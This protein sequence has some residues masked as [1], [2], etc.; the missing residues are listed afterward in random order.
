M[1]DREPTVRSRELG[2]RLRRVMGRS[3]FHASGI[4]REL[5]WSPSRVSRVLAEQRGGSSHAKLHGALDTG[6]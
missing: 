5:N 4:A 1:R 6:P 2:E 3:G